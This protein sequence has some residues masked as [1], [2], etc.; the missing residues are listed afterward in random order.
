V[1]LARRVRPGGR[2]VGVDSNPASL[3]VA[4]RGAAEVGAPVTFLAADASWLPAGRGR[5]DLA[6]CR[7]LLGHLAEPV[8][9]LRAM[10]GAV[11]PGGIVA[12]E[13]VCFGQLELATQQEP[14]PGGD[15]RGPAARRALG[16]FAALMMTTIRSQG[17]DPQIGPRLPA[18]FAAAGLTDITVVVREAPLPFDPSGE[19]LAEAL[20]ATGDA[21][22]AAGLTDQARLGQLRRTLRDL[23]SA[24]LAALSRSARLHQVAGHRPAP[25]GALAR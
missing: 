22:L 21:A 6:Y 10:A 24:E 7:L 2:V 13:D 20:D 11:R 14:A 3:R 25:A 16:Q 1:L 4:R 5:F 15:E 17:G 8:E 9:T 12:V 19:L 23:P 18:L